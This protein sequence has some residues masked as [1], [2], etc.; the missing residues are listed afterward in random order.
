MIILMKK[1]IIVTI[2]I[3]LILLS[4]ICYINIANASIETLSKF[5]SSGNEVKQIQQR[6]KDWG[7]YKGN[8][9]GVYGSKTQAAVKAF[10]KANG[11]KADRNCGGKNTCSNSE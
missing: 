8:V 7:Y 1:A 11:L 4:Y 2:G 9:D 3:M 10:Q 6:L 5:G